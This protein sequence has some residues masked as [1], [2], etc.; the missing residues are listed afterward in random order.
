MRLT[1]LQIEEQARYHLESATKNEDYSFEG[2]IQLLEVILENLYSNLLLTYSKLSNTPLKDNKVYYLYD[3][4]RGKYASYFIEVHFFKDPLEISKAEQNLVKY[5][6][7]KAWRDIFLNFLSENCGINCSYTV[8]FL[9][10]MRDALTYFYLPDLTVLGGQTISLNGVSIRDFSHL[11]TG[12]DI[13]ADIS[14]GECNRLLGK[15]NLNRLELNNEEFHRSFKT[16]R[17]QDRTGWL[18]I[19]NVG[20]TYGINKNDRSD[21]EALVKLFTFSSRVSFMHRDEINGSD[22]N[23]RI[24]RLLGRDVGRKPGLEFDLEISDSDKTDNLPKTSDMPGIFKFKYKI[25]RLIITATE[26]RGYDGSKFIEIA[27]EEKFSIF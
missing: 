22:L 1:P 14:I 19:L 4:E 17:Y 27:R 16:V 6:K 11:L 2:A 12:R 7:N 24:K 23:G 15:E 8:G 20:Y 10:T 9:K 13:H 18:S 21:V 5:A 25:E 26:K 3:E